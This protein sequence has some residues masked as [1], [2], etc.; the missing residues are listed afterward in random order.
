MKISLVVLLT[1]MVIG[2]ASAFMKRIPKK[3]H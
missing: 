3:N 1:V 2:S